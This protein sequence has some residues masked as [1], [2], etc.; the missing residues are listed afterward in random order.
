MNEIILCKYGE[1]V[2]KGANRKF[3]ESMLA[4]E[5]K[6][7]MHLYGACSVTHAH[8]TIVVEPLDDA[9]DIDGAFAEAKKVFGLVG[10]SRAL[11]VEKSME[12]IEA[13]L[14][15]W[16]PAMLAGYKTFKVEAK[17]SDKQFPLNSPQICDE[18]GGV[19]LD[20]M[21]RLKVNVR[22]PE[23][24]VRVEV[25]DTAAYIHAGQDKGAGGM[26]VG[27]AGKALLLLSGGIDSPVAGYM[28]SKR[29]VSLEATYFHAPPYTSE[30]AKQKVIDLAKQVAKYTGPIRL[31]IVNFT[32]IQM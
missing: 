24:V 25:R 7:R 6:H 31:H 27:S 19:I 26:P 11:K 21:P 4:R 5:M 8:S 2:L 12:A 30:R 32:D 13:G 10:V 29:G 14:R 23:I 15:S 1:I 3:F 17:R 18:C 20:T 28:I 16:V 9:F 22:N